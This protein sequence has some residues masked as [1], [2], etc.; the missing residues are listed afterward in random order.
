MPKLHKKRIDTPMIENIDHIQKWPSFL[1]TIVSFFTPKPL[2][3]IKQPEIHTK[4]DLFEILLFIVVFIVTLVTPFLYDRHTTENF[5]TPKEF[6]SKQVLA[7]AGIL[8][9]AR[10][11]YYKEINLIKSKLDLPLALFL[12]LAVLSISWNYNATSAIRDI[13]GTFLII[14]IF[15]YM[16]LSIKNRWQVDII[17][18]TVVFTG[19]ATATLGIFESYNWY[20]KIANGT[21]QF[22]RDEIFSGYIDPNAYYIPLFPQ[23]ADKNYSMFSIVSTFGNRNYLG[24]FTMFTSFVPLAFYFYYSVPFMKLLSLAL[25]GWTI[26]GMYITRCRAALLGLIIGIC[27]M[28]FML[29]KFDRDWKFVKKNKIFFIA[30]IL[31]VL[32]GF[33][34]QVTTAKSSTMLDKIMQTFSLD[35]NVSNTYERLWVWYATYKSFSNSLFKWLLGSGFGSYKHFFPLQEAETF[36][37]DN[38]ETFTAVTFRQAHNDW[39]QLVSELGL[40]GLGII[41]FLI[42]RF[43]KIIYDSVKSVTTELEEGEFAGDQVLIISLG[44][45]MAAQLIAAVPDFPFHRIETALYAVI[46]MALVVIIGESRFYKQKLSVSISKPNGNVLITL[47]GI[48]IVGGLLSFLFE[49]ITYI[50]DTKVRAAELK[51][52]HEPTVQSIAEAKRLLLEAINLDLL[53]GD[54]YLKLAT[55]YQ[56]EGKP[57]EALMYANKAWRNI[58]FNARSTYHSIVFRKMHIYYHSLNDKQKALEQAEY[59][60]YL[61]CS[62]ARSI[63]YY[64]IGKI[65]YELGDLHKAEWALTRAQ[66]YSNVA[67]QSSMILAFVKAMLQK[68]SEALELA[69]SVSTK[70]NDSD[71]ALLDII[72][73]SSSNLGNHIKGE[74]YAKKALSLNPN[75][76]VYKRNLGII[77]TRQNKLIEAKSYLEEAY[78]SDQ[79]PNQIKSEIEGLLASISIVLYNEYSTLTSSNPNDIGSQ[80]QIILKTLINSKVLHPDV[81]SKI[82]HLINNASD[83][84]NHATNTWHH[85]STK[86]STSINSNESGTL[87]TSLE[88]DSKVTLESKESNTDS[89]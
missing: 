11:L 21:I 4:L 9:A 48:I 32:L 5:L 27:F 42:W 22:A 10:F 73:I 15:Y 61:T 68:W 45:A 30:I 3:Q 18:W 16:L 53:P 19:L 40:I 59:G 49:R 55:V 20:F 82:D 6:W 37:D 85:P 65:C 26:Y 14:M 50:A 74:E 17:L 80:A 2:N 88:N 51:L 43:Y 72:A 23:L 1:R 84:K 81:K 60:R 34:I 79:L 64:Y 41:L 24:T 75:N 77:L 36:D 46:F 76:A 86:T 52:T 39:L 67:L 66:K 8:V 62:E 56:I 13:R 58:N 78:T 70:I 12:T 28:I 87:G 31:L 25:F 7:L 38:K 57:Q 29:L 47:C 69:Q 83:A 44:A 89:N 33:I 63:Y 71:P 54:P 35:R